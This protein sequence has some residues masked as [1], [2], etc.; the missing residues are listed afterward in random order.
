MTNMHMLVILYIYRIF[1]MAMTFF[2]VIL[3]LR[4]CL[5]NTISQEHH[6]RLDCIFEN[7]LIVLFNYLF[8]LIFLGKVRLI[9]KNKTMI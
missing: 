8:V 9:L 2:T 3:C 1:K 5:V 7:V 6:T 4:P